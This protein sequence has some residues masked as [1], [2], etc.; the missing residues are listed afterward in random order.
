MESQITV[1]PNY[2]PCME[3][4]RPADPKL[5]L[6]GWG[7]GVRV[8]DKATGECRGYLHANCKDAWV[9][10]NDATKFTFEII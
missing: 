6:G 9:A 4:D 2:R 5:V 8:K 10:K 1:D 7:V 3:C